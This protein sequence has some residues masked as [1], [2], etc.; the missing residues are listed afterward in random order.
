VEVKNCKRSQTGVQVSKYPQVE[1]CHLAELIF[2]CMLVQSCPA[3][4]E[5]IRFVVKKLTAPS[6]SGYLQLCVNANFLYYH[7]HLCFD[8]HLKLPEDFVLES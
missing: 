2:F 8:T 1:Y 3:V 5:K 4:A 6:Q 7:C